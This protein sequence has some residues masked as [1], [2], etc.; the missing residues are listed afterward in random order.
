MLRN[1]CA[2]FE[3]ETKYRHDIEKINNND[4]ARKNLTQW[5]ENSDFR[6]IAQWVL[7]ENNGVI[8]V[9]D[10]YELCINIFEQSS[11]KTKLTK[12]FA[13]AIKLN[14]DVNVI[15]LAKIIQLFSK[16]AQLKKGRSVYINV[17]AEDIIPYEPI[18]GSDEI[19]HYTILKKA[20]MCGIDDLKHLSLFKLTRNKYNLK[21]L[22]CGHWEYYASF[23]PLWSQRLTQFGAY[24]DHT[25]K[26]VIFN[27][28]TDDLIEEFY[29]LYGLEPD[30]QKKEIQN[31]SI[32]SIEKKYNW[33]WFNSQYKKNGL[34]DIYDE[35]L[36][37]FDVDGLY[38]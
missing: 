27:E 5:V 16:K 25:L 9:V 22:Y 21:E 36:E 26:K 17:E 12:E 8:S 6:S 2:S 14:I 32:G 10:I 29:R 38:Y 7:N 1:I 30:E 19:K 31:K 34:I 24:V 15:L 23:S 33:K 20:Y 11:L 35:E 3:I 13:N 4:D 18:I 28:E 37:E